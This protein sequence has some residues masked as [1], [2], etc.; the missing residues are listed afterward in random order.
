MKIILHIYLTGLLFSCSVVSAAISVIDDAGQSF[1]FE[2]PIKRIISLAPHITESLFA[3]GASNQIIATVTYSDYPEQAKQL[4]IIGDHSKYDIEKIIELKPELIIVWKSGNPVDQV[5]QLKRLGFNLFISDPYELEDVAKT[6]TNMGRILGTEPI[7][8]KQAAQYL[9]KLEQLRN[10]FKDKHKV[11]VF[12]Q[13]WDSPLITINNKHIINHVIN[14][15]GGIN[16][17]EGLPALAPRV[18][19]E[20]VIVKNPDVIV[21]GDAAGRESWLQNWLQW[22]QLKAVKKNHLYA[23]PADLITRHTPRIL[24]GL[25]KM[26]DS[27]DEV[28]SRS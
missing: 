20:S 27:L 6:I 1:V 10:E 14:L 13:V 18:S 25:E 2:K 28:R 24:S 11:N 22:K 9:N 8:N 17:F 4:A 5:Q 21:T 12:Y 19:V 26:C 7:A 15:C 16:I 3:A 23:I